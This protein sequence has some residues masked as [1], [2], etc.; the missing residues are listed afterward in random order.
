MDEWAKEWSK[1]WFNGWPMVTKKMYYNKHWIDQYNGFYPQTLVL[2]GQMY[3]HMYVRFRLFLY[4]A[5]T[6]GWTQISG[7]VIRGFTKKNGQDLLQALNNDVHNNT[8]IEALVISNSGGRIV[9]PATEVA[10]FYI[11]DNYG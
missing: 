4:A 9:Y 2:Y 1:E 3:N 8:H 7:P 5:N 6:Y 11:M 10:T